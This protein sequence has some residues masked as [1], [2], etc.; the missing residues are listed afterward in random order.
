MKKMYGG[1]LVEVIVD[2]H[3]MGGKVLIAGNGGL[4]AVA[5]HFSAELMGK[6]AGEVYIPC[7]ALTANTALLTALANDYGFEEVFA[8]QVRVLG[9]AHDVLIAMTTSASLNIFKAVD[10]GN[11]SGLTTVVISGPSSPDIGALLNYRM[12]CEDEVGVVQED[13]L[14]LLHHI[15]RE[16]KERLSCEFS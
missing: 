3:R 1:E 10:A 7:I 8:H 15:A 16:V 11:K 9:K 12:R 14:R 6:F 13:I 5:E 2:A 4:A